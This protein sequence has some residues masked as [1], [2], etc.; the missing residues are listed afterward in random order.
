MLLA[1]VVRSGLEG[2]P[3]TTVYPVQTRIAF[4]IIPCGEF[5]QVAIQYCELKRTRRSFSHQRRC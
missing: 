2:L 3:T 1:H 5:R 4:N